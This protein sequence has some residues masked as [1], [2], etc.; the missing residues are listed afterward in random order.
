MH[1]RH[2]GKA[3]EILPVDA[4]EIV[5]VFSHDLQKIIRRS[6]HE[7]AFQNIRDK[8]HRTLEGLQDLIRL[9]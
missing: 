5:R 3:R 4:G 7:M 8:L 6:G 2:A 1:L 9:P